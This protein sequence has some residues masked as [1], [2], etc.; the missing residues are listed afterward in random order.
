MAV[1]IVE[2]PCNAQDAMKSE[3]KKASMQTLPIDLD[4]VVVVSALKLSEACCT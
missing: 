1:L 3:S 2:K 4:F